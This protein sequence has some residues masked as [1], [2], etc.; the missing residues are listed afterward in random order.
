MGPTLHPV[1]QPLAPRLGL[2]PGSGS[3]HGLCSTSPPQCVLSH[4][5]GE[6][7]RSYCCGTV[8]APRQES[9]KAWL[10]S[11]A[12][13]VRLRLLAASQRASSPPQ[14][15]EHTRRGVVD[16]ES[17]HCRSPLSGGLS[18]TA[19]SPSRCRRSQHRSPRTPARPTT[20]DHRSDAR[21]RTQPD[22]CSRSPR[23]DPM[24][25]SL[26]CRAKLPAR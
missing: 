11:P 9:T 17:C 21:R 5:V 3:R 1:N 18:P 16:S 25:W 24:R 19:P 20:P 7:D 12:P 10:L 2:V 6:V 14:A 8:G 13:S 23:H 22:S 4:E 26:W 15:G